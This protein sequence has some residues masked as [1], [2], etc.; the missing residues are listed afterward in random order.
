MGGRQRAIPHGAGADLQT[1]ITLT[2]DESA[3][4]V[5][6]EIEITRD[7]TCPICKGSG[8]EPGS[9][10]E[11]CPTCGGRGEVRQARQT[12]LGS[13]VQVT[14]CPTCNGAGKVIHNTCKH[15]RG[16][17]YERKT[18][19]KVVSIPAGVDNGNQIRLAGE[20]QPGENGG[21]RGNLYI[22]V[23]VKAA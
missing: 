3:E 14:T 7:E 16:R 9:S 5:E 23:K 20:G 12:I 17:G 13:L 2:F 10:P 22:E 4:G 18:I 8:A 6:K 21:P 19:K 1:S 15:C 11:T